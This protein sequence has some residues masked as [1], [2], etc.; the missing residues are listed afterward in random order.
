[1][2]MNKYRFAYESPQL[3]ALLTFA[4]RIVAE[5]DVRQS[6]GP[7]VIFLD[8]LYQDGFVGH[9]VSFSIE[10]K[11]T[12]VRGKTSVAFVLVCYWD[13][14]RGEE[15]LGLYSYE[16]FSE[17]LRS[18]LL[19]ASANNEVWRERAIRLMTK[20]GLLSENAEPR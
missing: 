5:E 14:P 15:E 11:T 13:C 16:E 20:H 10:F 18:E 17:C 12:V 3:H 1:M 6:N 7:D 4:L 2:A 19:S 8:M 9:Q